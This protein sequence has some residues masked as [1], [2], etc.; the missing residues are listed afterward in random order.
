VG[1][2]AIRSVHSTQDPRGQV[3]HAPKQLLVRARPKLS[4]GSIAIEADRTENGHVALLSQRTLCL[5]N[6]SQGPKATESLRF[7]YKVHS[8]VG[9]WEIPGHRRG[10]ERNGCFFKLR[11][12]VMHVRVSMIILAAVVF[13]ICVLGGASGCSSVCHPIV[14][15]AFIEIKGELVDSE[16]GEQLSGVPLEI[17]LEGEHSPIGEPTATVTETIGLSNFSVRV[18]TDS[19]GGMCERGSGN[20]LLDMMLVFAGTTRLDE[21]PR[22]DL[23]PLP[24][25]IRAIL[26]VDVDGSSTTI[27]VE[28]E[29]GMLCS[30]EATGSYCLGPI[31]VA[32]NE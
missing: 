8:G 3:V 25:P 28:I 17:Q 26:T 18:I 24:T 16:S 1:E 30:P 11:R 2:R 23:E 21:D 27:T 7:L 13:T 29:E 9:K 5:S 15:E 6:I 14:V 32:H 12:H 20:P 19:L 31:P 10:L 22:D 4:R